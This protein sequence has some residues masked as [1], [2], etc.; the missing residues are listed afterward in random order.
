MARVWRRGRRRRGNYDGVTRRRRLGLGTVR[1]TGSLSAHCWQS[2]CPGRSASVTQAQ[3]YS[4]VT[5]WN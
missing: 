4:A 1:P 5:H 2:R 3:A